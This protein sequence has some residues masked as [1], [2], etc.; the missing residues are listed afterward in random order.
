MIGAIAAAR[1]PTTSRS[2]GPQIS[3]GWKDRDGLLFNTPAA[4]IYGPK[5]ML[6]DQD[7]GSGGDF[8]PYGFRHLG[9]GKLIA[10]V[11]GAASSAFP[12]IRR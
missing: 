2:L 9:L 6:I 4:A 11:P 3:R 7:A 5:V 1:P 10:P 12:P 8:F